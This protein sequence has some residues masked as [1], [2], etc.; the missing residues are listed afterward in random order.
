MEKITFYVNNF[1]GPM[2]LLCHLIEKNEI[3]IYNIPISS[4]TDQYIEYIKNNQNKN[5][6]NMSEFVLM[7]STLLEIKSKMLIPKDTNKINNNKLTENESDPRNELI[8][9][10]IEYKK[11][12]DISEKFKIYEKKAS[13]KLYKKNNDIEKIINIK[14][15]N[16]NEINSILEDITLNYLFQIFENVMKRKEKKIDTIKNSFQYI[17]KDTYTIDK[18]IKHIKNLLIIKPKL[19]FNSIFN[20]KSSK[21]EIIVTF[22]A[23]LELI[24]LKEIIILQK[25]NFDNIIIKKNNLEVK[26]FE[27]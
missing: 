13:L 19:E 16:T 18:K 14:N 9:K 25:N 10:I 1:E 12:K 22:L 26:K 17:K 3:D 6:D 21:I 8:Q 27:T 4:L 24:K 2:D 23:I 5:I 11:F 15:N 20:K 7:A